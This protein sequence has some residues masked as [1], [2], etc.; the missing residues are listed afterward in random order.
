MANNVLSV[1]DVT[2]QFGGV[3]A[4][5]NLSLDTHFGIDGTGRRK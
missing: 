5:D 3:V 2:M 1:R 4:G